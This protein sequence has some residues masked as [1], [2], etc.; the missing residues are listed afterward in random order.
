MGK[1]T[2]KPLKVQ[3]AEQLKEEFDR[4]EYLRVNGGSDPFYEDGFNM[5]LVRNHI[6]YGKRMCEEQLSPEDYP[7]EY[8][9]EPPEKVSNYYMAQP[10]KIRKDAED[11]LTAYEQSKDR[12]YLLAVSNRLSADQ[13]RETGLLRILN[14]GIRLRDAISHG[15]LVAMR[16]CR[17]AW[18]MD[19]LREVREKVEKILESEKEERILPEGQLSLDLFGLT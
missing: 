8:Y 19:N 12:D 10:E 3:L 17:S 15:D 5:N 18:I 2:I 11:A 9:L 13:Q 6:I 14:Y 4:W 16:R 1:N 7:E